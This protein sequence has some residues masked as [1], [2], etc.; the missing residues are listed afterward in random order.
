MTVEELLER[1]AAEER[2]FAGVDFGS[3]DHP[4]KPSLIQEFILDNSFT[5]KTLMLGYDAI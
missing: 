3:V 4:R 5:I 1:Y 2:D